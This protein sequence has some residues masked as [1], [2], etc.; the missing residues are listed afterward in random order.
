MTTPP[1]APLIITV[2]HVH[3]CPTFNGQPGM[4][5]RGA[6]VWFAAHGLSWADFVAHGIPAETLAATGDALA[7]RVVAHARGQLKE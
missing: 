4:C 6:R 1:P 3:A 7:L 5:S 2:Q